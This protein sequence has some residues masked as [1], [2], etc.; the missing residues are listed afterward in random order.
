MILSFF[1]FKYKTC[2]AASILCLFSAKNVSAVEVAGSQL[3]I[4]G[5]FHGSVDYMDSDVSN[6][7]ANANPNDKLSAGDISISSNTTK[8][9]FKG[10]QNLE[11]GIR[12]LYQLEQLVDLDGTSNATFSTRNSYLG[13]GGKYGELL[14]GRHDTPFKLVSSRYSVLTDTVGDRRAILGASS[15]RGNQ[16]NL[17]A[18]NM[19]MWRND[20]E[21]ADGTFDWIIQFSA[22]AN[23]SNGAVDNNDRS[24]WGAWGQWS[25]NNF[26]LVL[27]H[28]S[29]S[30]IYDGEID[31][32]RIAA[33]NTF[34]KFTA[35]LIYETI[36][37]DLDAGGQGTLDRNAWGGNLT[38]TQDSWK[39]YAQVLSASSYAMVQD[40][41]ALMFSI[42]AEKSL[43]SALTT[44]VIYSQT[45]NEANGSYQAVDGGHGDE[46]GTLP[47]GVHPRRYPSGLNILSSHHMAITRHRTI[48]KR[49]HAII[50]EALCDD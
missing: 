22:D 39:Y 1:K 29:W 5:T 15:T 11:G 8:I 24:M 14:L 27:A 31:A 49:H 32:T 38:Y 40:S 7:V 41:G 48:I 2:F 33:K 47:G 20:K 35:A 37:H 23:K 50:K 6:T 17:R 30:S 9:G 46:L 19:I 21:L 42:A 28:D 36:Q 18:E 16:L 44:Y 12:V 26:S 10:E 43:N 34:G 45:D 4:Y 13:I 25:R 3:N